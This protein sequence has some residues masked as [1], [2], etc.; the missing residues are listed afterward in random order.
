M[1][2]HPARN[3]HS[4]QQY[5]LDKTH[6]Q[7]AVGS[8][9]RP[10]ALLH[11]SFSPPWRST[12]LR[13]S[14][15]RRLMLKGFLRRR[16]WQNW[17]HPPRRRSTRPLQPS[18]HPPTTTH[19]LTRPPQPHPHHIYNQTRINALRGL[20]RGALSAQNMGSHSGHAPLVTRYGPASA[21][22]FGHNVWAYTWGTHTHTPWAHTLGI[23]FGYTHSGQATWAHT[24][25]A[26]FGHTLGTCVGHTLWAP[27]VWT[28]FGTTGGFLSTLV[29]DR[30]THTRLGAGR[31]AWSGE[32]AGLARGELVLFP[33][34][35]ALGGAVQHGLGVGVAREGNE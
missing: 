10:W 9:W 11:V 22:N 7:S 3:P 33:F 19:E 15:L 24:L 32:G 6:P 30:H 23:H 29:A 5:H 14:R 18:P 13:R 12:A 34:G 31:C 17:T 25:G 1:R 26:R 28:I 21:S 35:I 16:R 4:A 8:A 2:T 27:Q 20:R